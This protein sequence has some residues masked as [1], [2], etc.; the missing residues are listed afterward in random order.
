[1]KSTAAAPPRE[2]LK[3]GFAEAHL[4]GEEG[5]SSYIPWEG[6][7]EGGPIAAL[8]CVG[9]GDAISPGLGRGKSSTPLSEFAAISP[10]LHSFGERRANCYRSSLACIL[11]KKQGTDLIDLRQIFREM[12]GGDF[13]ASEATAASK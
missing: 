2:V 4:T 3:C 6:L 9:L 11:H 7:E 8:T 12:A 13:L 10:F 1:M 5:G